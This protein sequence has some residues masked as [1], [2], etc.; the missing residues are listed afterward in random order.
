[1]CHSWI[2]PPPQDMKKPSHIK[3]TEN[4]IAA[5]DPNSRRHSPV[6][7]SQSLMVRSSDPDIT[8]CSLSPTRVKDLTDPVWPYIVLRQLLDDTSQNFIVLSWDPET[9][10]FRPKGTIDE[11]ISA[12]PSNVLRQSSSPTIHSLIVLSLEPDRK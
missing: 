5:L 1:M 8:R 9:N 2:F 12:C 6:D 3:V 11:I 4:T 7:T 10:R